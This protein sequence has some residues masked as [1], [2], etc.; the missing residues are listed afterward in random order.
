MEG[1]VLPAEIRLEN[2]K[3]SVPER[4]LAVFSVSKDPSSPDSARPNRL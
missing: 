4:F 1:S 3:H 2:I